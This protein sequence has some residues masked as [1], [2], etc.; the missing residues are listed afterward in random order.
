MMLLCSTVVRFSGTWK[1]SAPSPVPGKRSTAHE[2]E[3]WGR[4]EAEAVLRP[5]LD[6]VRKAGL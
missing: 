5:L 4:D 6:V 2:P 1:P 3:V